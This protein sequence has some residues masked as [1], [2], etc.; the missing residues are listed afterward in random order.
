MLGISPT[1]LYSF[2]SIY[3]KFELDCNVQ[4]ST[5]SRMFFDLP[6]EFDNF[7]NIGFNAMIIYSSSTI[8]VSTTITNRRI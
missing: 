5:G 1:G 3:A 6:V 8:S 4:I 2:S 7:N